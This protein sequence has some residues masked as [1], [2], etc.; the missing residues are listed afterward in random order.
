MIAACHDRDLLPVVTF[1]HFTNPLW[2]DAEGGWANPATAD[3][4][5]HV[6][7]HRRRPLR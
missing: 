1:H 7:W 4:F 3:R 5:A 2:I 6:I